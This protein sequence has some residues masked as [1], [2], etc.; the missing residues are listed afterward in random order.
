MW[1]T[2][3]PNSHTSIWRF[4]WR[5]LL[6]SNLL[7]I[8]LS[9]VTARGPEE[10]DPTLSSGCSSCVHVVKA[11]GGFWEASFLLGEKPN[12]RLSA[13]FP[14]ILF[15]CHPRKGCSRLSQRLRIKPHSNNVK[16]NN[17]RNV[18]TWS[19]GHP[20]MEKGPLDHVMLAPVV[21]WKPLRSQGSLKTLK[22]PRN[23]V[24][25][26]LR[27]SKPSSHKCNTMKKMLSTRIQY[28]GE[29]AICQLQ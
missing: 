22:E 28:L 19:P 26:L 25:K 24:W 17:F 29:L 15:V 8:T 2:H 11:D 18:L 9:V 10:A 7:T 13:F 12:M 20:Y 6:V 23:K 1:E 27:Y 3:L 5:R 21:L 14:W 4:H 16:I